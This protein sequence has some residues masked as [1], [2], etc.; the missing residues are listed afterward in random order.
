MK[1]VSVIVPTL[2][3]EKHLGECLD[4]ILSSDYPNELLSVIVCDGYSSDQTPQ[5]ITSYAEKHPCITYLRNVRH[6]TPFALNMG[7]QQNDSDVVIV[8]G[9]H[10]VITPDYIQKCVHYLEK[11][12]LIGCVGGMVENRAD[13]EISKLIGFSMTQSFGVGPVYFRTGAKEGFVDTVPFGAY[14]R[15]VFDKVGMFDTNLTRDW[16]DDFNFRVIQ[17]GY[18][19][20]LSKEIKSYHYILRGNFSKLYKQYY[21]YGYW[22]VYVN[23]KHRKITTFRQIIPFF[24][25]MFLFVGLM[26]S[27]YSF[28]FAIAYLSVIVI[29]FL[30]AIGFSFRVKLKIKQR[31]LLIYCFLILHISYGLGYANGI[32]DFM[33]NHMYPDRKMG[34]L[35]R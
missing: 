3:E 9:A 21:Q 19:I 4:S 14:K 10:S 15:E 2:N 23:R 17:A 31:V 35:T 12:P 11:D 24:F 1:T 34:E 8:L 18:K 7:I 13:N 29:Y 25:V 22:K 27:L 33:I 16:D 26:I 32:G 5:I 30:I 28:P 20:F 6:T